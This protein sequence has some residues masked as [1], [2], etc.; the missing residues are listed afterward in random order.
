MCVDL[1]RPE[2]F[3]TLDALEGLRVVVDV[4]S[5]HRTSPAALARHCLDAGFVFLEASSDRRVVDALLALD[6]SSKPG[7]VVLGA[8]IFTGLSNLL[9]AEAVRRRPDA[10]HLEIGVRSSPFSGGGGGT[11]DLMADLLTVPSRE[12]VHGALVE[13]PS[14]AAGP[15]LPFPSGE[16]ACLTVAFP[17]PHML[18]RSTSVANVAMSM[19]PKPAWLRRAFLATPRAILQSRAFSVYLRFVFG[20]LRRVVLARRPTEVELVARARDASGT[21]LLGLVAEDG[22]ATGGVAI[23]AI[24]ELLVGA[25]VRGVVTVDQTSTLET[26]CG[27][28][29]ELDPASTPRFVDISD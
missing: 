27:A 5:S 25:S 26:V 14:V 13:G 17:E 7:A 12:A 23:A 11:V 19:A 15:L 21:T 3:A 6:G 28:M 29:A 9:A 22:M 1:D 8:G 18:F 20:C 2:T 24:A 10:T 16:H 4:S